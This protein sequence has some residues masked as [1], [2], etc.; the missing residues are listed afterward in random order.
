MKRFLFVLTII[1]LFSSC[2]MGIINY[3]LINNTD[4][5]VTL[6][7]NS[8]YYKTEYQVPANS[9]KD[10]RHYNSGHFIIKDCIYPIKIYNNFSSSR[11]EY[12][13]TFEIQIFNT[14]D[15]EYILSIT[16]DFQ[17]DYLIT[18]NQNTPIKIYT[19]SL[20]TNKIRLKQNNVP[21]DN[22]IL[23]DNKLYI[24]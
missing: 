14:T 8:D 9:T 22:F 13:S 16:D 21:V 23:Q 19:P 2:S 17:G 4:Y 20:N 5:D 7:D 3:Q 15:K 1:L 6:I 11:I 24:F 18:A 12:L 10:I